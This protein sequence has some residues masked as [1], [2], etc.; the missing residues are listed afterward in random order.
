MMLR[1]QI[2]LINKMITFCLMLTTT[3]LSPA[4]AEEEFRQITMKL[5]RIKCLGT[6]KGREDNI[7][8]TIAESSDCVWTSHSWKEPCDY[9]TY[10]GSVEKNCPKCQGT[11]CSTGV[12]ITWAKDEFFGTAENGPTNAPESVSIRACDED[13]SRGGRFFESRSAQN[14]VNCFEVVEIVR[15][16]YAADGAEWL[17]LGLSGKGQRMRN[18]WV[19]ISGGPD[20]KVDKDTAYFLKYI[21]RNHSIPEDTSEDTYFGQVNIINSILGVPLVF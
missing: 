17:L 2:I 1:T 21:R 7:F 14:D 11:K 6:I 19:K 3:F 15:T 4:M 20:G 5:H 8:S 10:S 18:R 9:V 12:N 16:A 13:L